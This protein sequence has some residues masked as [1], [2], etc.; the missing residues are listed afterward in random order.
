MA[1]TL[2][3]ENGGG[4]QNDTVACPVYGA[5][6]PLP[7]GGLRLQQQTAR[8][9]CPNGHEWDQVVDAAFRVFKV[10]GSEQAFKGVCP[11]CL[12]DTLVRHSGEFTGQ[13]VENPKE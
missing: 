9:R 2:T 4:Q 8:Y 12:A 6:M 5:P 13:P 7:S 1:E 11:S 10:D 3:T